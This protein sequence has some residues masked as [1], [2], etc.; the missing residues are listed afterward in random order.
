[1]AFKIMEDVRKGKGLK[2]EYEKAMREQN[3]PEWYLDSCKK[4]KYMFPKAHAAA[5]VISAIRLGWYKVHKPLE[6]YAA[7]FTVAPGGFDA[8]IVLRGRNYIMQT[9]KDIEK[10]GVDAT[11][12]EKEQLSALL[13]ANE[14]MARGIQFLPI[15]LYKSDAH[16]Y[17][18]ENGNIRLPF[19]SL[20]GLG[21]AA[22]IKIIE[23]RKNGDF[24]SKEDL[25]Q[26]TSISKSVVEVLSINGVLDSLSETNQITFDF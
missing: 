10:K 13:I 7:Y 4:I 2:E 3:I 12:K 1:M 17:L 6:F 18:P 25:L 20:S 16:A 23:E 15:D 24:I 5:Y 8:E 26:R 9:V 11:Q 14:C 19:S 22:A 21:K